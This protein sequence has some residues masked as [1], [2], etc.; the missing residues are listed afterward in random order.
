MTQK[1][2]RYGNRVL[3]DSCAFRSNMRFQPLKDGHRRSFWCLYY[4]EWKNGGKL[5]Y[6]DMWT[7][8]W[9]EANEILQHRY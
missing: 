2:N 8:T 5:R 1:N 6:C 9:K 4:Q 3:C 7:G